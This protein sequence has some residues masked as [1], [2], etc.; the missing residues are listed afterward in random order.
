MDYLVFDLETQCINNQQ[1]LKGLKKQDYIKQKYEWAQ[2]DNNPFSQKINLIC[3]CVFDSRTGKITVY[4]KN[5][6]QEIAKLIQNTDL[7]IVSFNGL[8]FDYE[9]LKRF[10]FEV[11]AD[12]IERSFDLIIKIASRYRMKYASLKTLVKWNYEVILYPSK[13]HSSYN[14]ILKKCIVDVKYTNKLYLDYLKNNV[15]INLNEIKKNSNRL[16]HMRPKDNY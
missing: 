6:V 15:K 14:Q 13:K 4:K 1:T 9:V 10:D 11:N 7:R 8:N 2:N 5:D 3:G 16:H 12:I